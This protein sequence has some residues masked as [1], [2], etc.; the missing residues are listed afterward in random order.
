MFGWWFCWGVWPGKRG[1]ASASTL[2]ATSQPAP[3]SRWTRWP[4]ATSTASST[5]R[6]SPSD[7]TTTTAARTANPCMCATLAPASTT[8]PP[9]GATMTHNSRYRLT[10]TCPKEAP[11]VRTSWA[12]LAQHGTWSAWMGSWSRQRCMA[13]LPSAFAVCCGSA[14][15]STT[16]TATASSVT[17]PPKTPR[18]FSTT[19]SPST[20][21]A[22]S[23]IMAPSL[24]TKW[25]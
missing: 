2:R 1:V 14:Q 11:M 7:S 23:Y 10:R 17:W 21:V 16:S 9:T 5:T 8:T 18:Q 4:T 19:S 12:R 22:T 3:A 25:M 20:R 24:P 15:T 13:P 6:R